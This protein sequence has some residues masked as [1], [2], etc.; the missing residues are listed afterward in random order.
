MPASFKVLISVREKGG[1]SPKFH[2]LAMET[3]ARRT[4]VSTTPAVLR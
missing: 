3:S 1:G 2:E 4:P